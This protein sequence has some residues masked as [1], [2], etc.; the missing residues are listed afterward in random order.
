MQCLLLV[1]YENFAASYEQHLLQKLSII[2]KCLLNYNRD[3]KKVCS[4]IE[5][6]RTTKLTQEQA[7]EIPESGFKPCYLLALHFRIRT[8]DE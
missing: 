7:D 6:G 8:V 2:C 1:S 5:D 3:R 4:W